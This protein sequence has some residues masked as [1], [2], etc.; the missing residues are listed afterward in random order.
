VSAPAPLPAAF[1][2]GVFGLLTCSSA[3]GTLASALSGAILGGLYAYLHEHALAATT[4]ARIGARVPPGSSAL[5][6]FTSTGE[7]NTLTTQSL[8]MAAARVSVA[9]I[10]GDLTAQIQPESVGPSQDSDVELTMVLTRYPEQDTAAAVKARPRSARVQVE[11]VVRVEPS[12]RIHVADPTHS[13]GAFARSDLLSWGGFGLVCGAVAGA[14]NGGG[15]IGLAGGAAVLASAWGLFGLFGLFAGGLYGLWAGRAVSRRR[16]TGLT[17]LLSP[18]TS[19]LLA[20]V[21]GAATSQD[22]HSLDSPGCQQLTLS[23]NDSAAGPALT[24]G[25][26]CG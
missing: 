13:T 17:A 19:N 15:W 10:S 7:P 18:G 25:Q 21:D 3:A 11:L 14:V 2:W 22:L 20:W 5:A 8:Q 16:L 12:G 9:T 4:L 26:L 23:F 6:L 24:S 1:T